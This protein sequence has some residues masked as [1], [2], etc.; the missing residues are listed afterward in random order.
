MDYLSYIPKSDLPL[1]TSWVINKHQ[2]ITCNRCGCLLPERHKQ[3]KKNINYC[4]ECQLRVKNEQWEEIRARK[5]YIKRAND[6]KT[7]PVCG[8]KFHSFGRQK[9]C[10]ECI[11]IKATKDN[12]IGCKKRYIK[13]KAKTDKKE[14][15]I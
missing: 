4:P 15:S 13:I 14:K 1:F 3:G 5:K 8:D 2:D 12:R 11:F 6:Y 10:Q 9:Y 7:C